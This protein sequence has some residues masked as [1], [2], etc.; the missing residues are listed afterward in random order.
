MGYFNNVT[1][2][3]DED[4]KDYAG[5]AFNVPDFAKYQDK[6]KQYTVTARTAYRPDKIAWD[7]YGDDSMSWIIDEINGASHDSFYE[8]GKV[9][10]FLPASF[11]NQ[12][13]VF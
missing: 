1:I 11:V 10:F 7:V 12:L 2:L 4:G 3:V 5:I 6:Y 13:G 9:I 8:Q